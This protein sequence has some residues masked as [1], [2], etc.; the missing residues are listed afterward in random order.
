MKIVILSCNTGGG[1]NSA[2][3]AI[4]EYLDSKEID[5]E[6]KDAL[7]FDSRLKSEVISKGHVWL[8]KKAP[9][10]F[11]AGYHYAEKHPSK[12]GNESMMYIIMKSGTDALR[13]YLI[14]N[15][16]D[17]VICTHVFA[18]MMMT[19]LKNEED[20][21][22]KSYFVA[23]DYTCYPGVDEVIADA[24]F[25]AHPHLI[26]DY[27][28]FGIPEEKLVPT[29]IPIKRAFYLSA[30]QAFLLLLPV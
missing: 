20:F 29:G 15:E 6:I 8:Y 9:A 5:C 4:K 17:A 11:G 7:A 24:F 2:A 18:S 14:E 30:N 19:E 27:T 21:S 26:P 16:I 13:N 1:H 23:T 10:V 25:I 12:P 28:N 3:A 22:V